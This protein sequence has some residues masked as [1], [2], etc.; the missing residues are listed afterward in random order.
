MARFDE[1]DRAAARE[2][3]LFAVEDEIKNEG[4]YYGLKGVELTWDDWVQIQSESCSLEDAIQS[5]IITID[6]LYEQVK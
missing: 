6:A 3:H 2:E 1:D 4:C 5:A